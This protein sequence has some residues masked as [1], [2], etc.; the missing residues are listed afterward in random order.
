MKF[1]RS[2][3]LLAFGLLQL[4]AGLTAAQELGIPRGAHGAATETY[5]Q[6]AL[7]KLLQNAAG[8][9]AAQYGVDPVIPDALIQADNRTTEARI[10][11]GRKLFFEPKLSRDN[12]VSCA[13]CHDV[14]RGFCDQRPTSEG[15]DA[16][17]GKRNAPTVM[18]IGELTTM[19]WDGRSP[20]IEHQAMQPIVNPIEMG[21]TAEETK[22]I[23]PIKDDPEYQKLFQQAYGR[24]VNYADIGNALAVFERTLKFTDAP[25]FRYLKGDATAISEDA[26]AG[27]ELFNG[28]ARC[29][30]CHPMSVSRPAGS[31]SRFHNIGIAART[32]DFEK[33]AEEAKTILAK[34]SSFTKLEELALNSH[35][36]ELGRALYTGRRAD[37]GAFRTPILLNVGITFPYMHD[38]SL[39]TLWDVI[40][41]YNKGGEPNLYLDGGIEPLNLT[42]REVDQLVAFLFSLTD[43]RFQKENDAAQTRMLRQSRQQRATRDP[44]IAGRKVLQFQYRLEEK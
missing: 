15:V 20:T 22:I 40:D 23:A 33:I 37:I 7:D 39:E 32:Q 6:Q 13:T 26:K 19:F 16:Q 17:L 4:V 35:Y 42:E 28:K 2:V 38:G 14:T 44:D 21:M 30:T 41:H 5:Q 9:T 29:M 10:A 12:S 31:D 11:L 27:W 24:D 3:P 34:D 8:Q 1:T 36:G 18:N 43:V 25:F